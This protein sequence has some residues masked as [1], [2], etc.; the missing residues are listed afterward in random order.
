KSLRCPITGFIP[1]NKY[2]K[3]SYDLI[4][5]KKKMKYNMNKNSKNNKKLPLVSIIVITYECGDTIETCL[6]SLL[7]Q[8][9]ENKE[10][11][12]VDNFS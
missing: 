3:S 8:T 7:A 11:I 1:L 10:I 9:Y 6:K 12:L 2:L 4:L 5:F